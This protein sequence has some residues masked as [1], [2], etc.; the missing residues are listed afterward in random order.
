MYFSPGDAEIK[1][2]NFA[3]MNKI[4]TG[5]QYFPESKILIS[6]HTD[7]VGNED[8]NLALSL[9]RA[10]NVQK[11]LTEVGGIPGEFIESKGFGES[12]PIANNS[13]RADREKN[14]RIEVL[15]INEPRK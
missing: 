10:Q 15:I 3:L 8:K 6:G 13:K 2:R 4:I 7:A 11:F 12:K 1:S 9:L 14:R 5:I